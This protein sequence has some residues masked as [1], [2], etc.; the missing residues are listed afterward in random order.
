[1]G[2]ESSKRLGMKQIV[3]TLI[4]VLMVVGWSCSQKIAGPKGADGSFDVGEYDVAIL[5]YENMLK[6]NPDDPRVNYQI[7]ESFRL[8]N[9][10]KKSSGFYETAFENGF[11]GDSV[12]FYYAFSLKAK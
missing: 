1:M 2:V 7:A 12:R 4:G 3:L 9:R 8:S 6:D 10:I 5:A 11:V